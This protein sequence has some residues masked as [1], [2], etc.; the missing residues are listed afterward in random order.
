M[1]PV[2]RREL[3]ERFRRPRSAVL[4]TLWI[5]AVGLL[6]YLVYQL[7]R[8]VAQNVFG[9]GGTFVAAATMGRFMFESLL[10]LLM[11][12]V[13]L[14][15]PGGVALSIVGERERLT[16]PL[17]QV[18]Q[19]SAG[20]VV[21]GKLVSS[22]SYVVLLLVAVAPIVAL[23]SLFGGVSLREAV[24]GLAMIL[25]TALTLGCV[26][27]WVSARARSTRGAVAGAYALASLLAFLSLGLMAAEIIAFRPSQEVFFPVGG[28]E[29]YAT[30]INPYIGM[31]SAVEEP[32][33]GDPMTELTVFA[34]VNGLLG[35]RS[36]L[37][38]FTE[39]IGG[40]V[41]DA[42][43][44]GEDQVEEVELPPLRP[45]RGPIWVRTVAVYGA[46]SLLA[47]LGA[48]RR[49]TAP[50]GSRRAAKASH[51]AA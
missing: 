1:N 48:T 30:W 9:A 42:V 11:T 7:S 43:V 5:L 35:L 10:L 8:L 17:L 36:G 4:F 37:S 3:T 29:V 45:R 31:V 14:I 15:V 38:A 21:R 25:L 22:M 44:F 40:A 33:D 12:G 32:I 26:S 28:R 51:A 47:L 50:D 24:A 41:P 2:A 18:S 19:L 49:V 27:L 39:Q 13:V 6:G 23:P 34:P 16:L 20:Q 46:V